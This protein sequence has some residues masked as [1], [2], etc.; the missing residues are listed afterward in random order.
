MKTAMLFEQN[1]REKLIA[2]VEKLCSA[3]RITLGPMG[4]TVA[5]CLDGEVPHL[6]KDGVTVANSISLPDPYENIGAALV[7]EAAQRS[8][9]VAGDG[10][11]TATVLAHEIISQGDKLIAAGHSTVEVLAGMRAAADEVLCEIEKTKVEITADRLIDVATI[12]ANGDRNLGKIIS[13]A[14]KRVGGEGAVSVQEAKGYDTSL[15]IV[16]G[17]YI[18][19]GF[20]SPYFVT[21]SAKQI[22]E[23]DQPDI[24][25]VNHD[26]T[27]VASIIP[28]LERVASTQG[29]L[30]IICNSVAGEALQALVLNRIKAGLKVCVIKSPEFAGAR[31]TALQ[32]LAS[33]VGGKV[34]TDASQQISGTDLEEALGKVKKATITNRTTL[35][36][37]TQ[38]NDDVKKKQKHAKSVLDDPGATLDDKKIAARRI[39][40]LSD[41]IA[42]VQVGGATEAEMK[43]RRDRADDALHAAKAALKE[44]VQAGGGVALA[45]V[46][47]RLEKKFRAKDSH[48]AGALAFLTALESPL[49]QIAT[50]CSVSPDLVVQ[51]VKRLSSTYGYDGKNDKY[52][53]MFELG[54][55]DP[56]TVITAA[57]EHSLSVAC[58]ILSIGCIIIEEDPLSG[59]SEVAYFDNV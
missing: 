24:L 9:A 48:G 57:I 35:L 32:D 19:R 44:G 47:K 20:E 38:Q 55:L 37:G 12:S 14:I 23:L 4:K 28:A 30:L 26:L 52:G 17:T 59:D 13:D 8:A 56:H 39:K 2:G 3:V 50:N 27:S 40:R 46:K 41:G 31:V 1:A 54:I 42:V 49:R 7:R 21:D 15:T 25:I 22:A 43:E 45:R 16:E 11:T 10:T 6:T 18:D 5:I 58:N 34:I 29:S 36:F 33:L 53:D 51:K